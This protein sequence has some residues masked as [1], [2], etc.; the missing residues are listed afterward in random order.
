MIDN[1]L[2]L[3]RRFYYRF[4]Q[5]IMTFLG[6]T[7]GSFPL[8][9]RFGAAYQRHLSLARDFEGWNS[10]QQEDYM[11][12]KTLETLLFAERYIPYYQR[13]FA[14][15]EFKTS[16]FKSLS[17]IQ[18]VPNITKEEIK[19]NLRLLYSFRKEFGISY[20]TGGSTSVPMKFFLPLRTSRGKEKAYI[21]HILS[22]LGYEPRDRT[23]ILKGR[24]IV[25]DES[26]RVWQYEPVDN[27]LVLSSNHLNPDHIQSMLKEI[28]KYQ[29]K[30]IYGFPS[31]VMDFL[32]AAQTVRCEGLP[33][34]QGVFL[35]S[36]NVF[37]EQIA[38][39][40]DFFDC[41]V[42]TIF[43][44]SERTAIAYKHNIGEY[45]FLNSYGLVRNVNGQIVS[46]SFDN[47]VMPLINYEQRDYALGTNEF[48]DGTDIIR[49]SKNIEGRIQEFLI[50]K[51]RRLVSITTMGAGH[52]STLQNIEAI[53]Y[54]QDEP[55]IAELRIMT[56]NPHDL[57][58]NAIR[59]ELERQ[60]GSGIAFEVKVVDWIEKSSMG[61][62]VL[63]LQKID[64]SSVETSILKTFDGH[65]PP[66]PEKPSPKDPSGVGVMSFSSKRRLYESMPLFLKKSV[67]LVPFA[68][69][70]GR[71]YRK[72]LRR[73]HIFDHA[74]R[75]E[76]L[77]YQES[78]LGEILAFATA[79]VPAYHRYRAI[80]E[81]H[82]PFEAL[83]AFPILEK[84]TV[85]QDL[86]NY[87]PAT[88][89][90]I[91]HYQISTG[92]TSGNQ[93]KIFVDDAS[94]AIEMA[95]MHR[96]WSRV[97]YFPGSRKAVFRGVSFPNLPKGV[98]WQYNPIY[99]EIQFSPFAMSEENL[100]A[101]IRA[102]IRYRPAFLHGYPSAIDIVSEY[103]LRN[104]LTKDLPPIKAVLLGSEGMV[105]GQASR[106]AR[107]FNTRVFSWYGHSERVILA[108]GCEANNSYHHFP[109]YGI[110]EMI[111]E[112]NTACEHEGDRGELIGTGLLNRSMPFIRYRTGDF[113]TRLGPECECGRCWD[114]FT[115]VEGRWKQDM[116]IGHR[117]AKISIAALNMHGP[118]FERVTRYQ[119]YQDRI[120]ECELH[121]MVAP[122][123][124]EED[125]L[126]IE[127][128]Y[129]DKVRDQLR[130][131]V[132][133]VGDIPL[134]DRGKL[135]L[136]DSKL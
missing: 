116:I 92:G 100:P 47:F 5:P 101:Y 126:Q 1:I 33:E 89:N 6:S 96:Q 97:G 34:I 49:T 12:H 22:H 13:R 121:I 72:T 18:R 36:E 133:I 94:Q 64:L 71:A 118:L 44:H 115:N 8:S 59:D 86:P 24:N 91:P 31:A 113:A 39:I 122:G 117:G 46:T 132:K 109:D 124:G 130:L 136:L 11:F 17:D 99:R 80:V 52:F 58:L 75:T 119:Y 60:A 56:S 107:A 108:G 81:R 70:A 19:Q 48:Y 110:L 38:Q 53:Q 41:D 27:H 25:P 127:R 106:I 62:R 111:A 87:L 84:E 43:G 123:F 28:K 66:A 73:K 23:I 29:P 10:Q 40:R 105:E 128:A 83:K 95:F 3:Y 104:D 85:Q 42:V 79:Q 134:T 98:Y 120:G 82:R 21:N 61:K 2:H 93:L 135:K 67:S 88:F 15:S 7:Y 76:I 112:N 102:L 114:R 32:R 51:D 50:T 57:D 54:S 30:F 63:C 68:F 37:D 69:V 26:K 129:R 45:H 78:A 16:S 14:E 125:R 20:F 65:Q 103:I 55:G 9:F 77:D 4:P 74:S 90:E 35:G 131:S